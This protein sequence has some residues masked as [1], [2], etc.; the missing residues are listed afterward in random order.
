MSRLPSLNALRAFEAVARCDVVNRRGIDRS[1][2]ARH[3]ACL[4]EL[5][6]FQAN[7]DFALRQVTGRLSI[8]RL[9]CRR[10]PTLATSGSKGFS[11][12]FAMRL[13]IADMS[14]YHGSYEGTKNLL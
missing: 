5:E 4:A 9:S 10:H 8:H 3:V 1:I 7:M 2:R 13:D 11:I 6:H 14:Q 12:Y